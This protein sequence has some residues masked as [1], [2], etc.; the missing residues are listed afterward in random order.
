MCETL[1]NNNHLPG[2]NFLENVILGVFTTK[3]TITRLVEVFLHYYFDVF[4]K[5]IMGAGDFSLGTII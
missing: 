1:L 3:E 5:C 4:Y 2:T